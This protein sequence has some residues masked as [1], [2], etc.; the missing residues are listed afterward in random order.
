[1]KAKTKLLYLMVMMS[2]A[3]VMVVVGVFALK[4]TT[5]QV[6][7]SITFNAKGINATIS[8]G[9]LTNCSFTDGSV[10]GTS[11]LKAITINTDK[12]KSDIESEFSSWQGL[13][14]KFND[15][16]SGN[17]AT[18]TFSI[19]NNATSG[20]SEY[21]LAS[22]T[23]SEGTSTNATV[24]VTSP[25]EY[26]D[27]QQTVQYTITFKITDTTSN[28]SLSGFSIKFSL[29]RQTEKPV[30]G[31]TVSLDVEDIPWGGNFTTLTVWKYD[32][33]TEEITSTGTYTINNVVKMQLSNIYSVNNV[34]K[35]S[36]IFD[37][38]GTVIGDSNIVAYIVDGNTE[39]YAFGVHLWYTYTVYSDV[40]EVTKNASFIIKFEGGQE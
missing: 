29:E 27:P 1:M 2:I 21:I 18:I 8:Q 35:S 10:A 40:Y 25:S 32:G 15:D 12:T 36:S 20:S 26:I 31:Y 6:G 11:K 17:T 4:S 3:M 16:L 37:A 23:T 14:L 9:T 39:T 22:V 28:A 7:G 13:S 5:F 38:K 30:G 24:S 34:V 19:T 33:T